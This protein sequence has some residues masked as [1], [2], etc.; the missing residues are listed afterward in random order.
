MAEIDVGDL[1]IFKSA[2]I[3]SIYLVMNVHDK[4]RII[5]KNLHNKKLYSDSLVNIKSYYKIQKRK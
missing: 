3:N 2:I 4:K 1:L 5:I